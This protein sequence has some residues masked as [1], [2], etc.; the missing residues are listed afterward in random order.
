MTIAYML[1]LLLLDEMK[2]MALA[3]SEK[4]NKF[5]FKALDKNIS[6]KN[7]SNTLFALL[8]CYFRIGL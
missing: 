7:T 8:S 2:H 3:F 1:F 4:K 6:E 5:I